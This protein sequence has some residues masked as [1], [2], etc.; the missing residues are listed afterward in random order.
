MTETTPSAPPADP[1]KTLFGFQFVTLSRRWRKVIH[2]EL[3]KVGLTD[4]TWAPLV[5]LDAGDGISQTELADQLALDT[6]S[7]VRLLDIL[8]ERGFIERRV[9]PT[10]RRARLIYLTPEGHA[11]VARIKTHLNA[12]EDTLLAE[13]SETEVA[14][15]L[16]AMDIIN[17]SVERA[18][19]QT[20]KADT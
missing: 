10:D 7:L 5:H 15:L 1:A 6:S 11:E 4:A 18:L 16:R 3:A 17:M 12:V 9:A 19:T 20:L 14:A 8:A 2:S 13:L